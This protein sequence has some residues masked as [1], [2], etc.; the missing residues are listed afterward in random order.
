MK[1]KIYAVKRLVSALFLCFTLAVCGAAA[2]YAEE[3]GA[4]PPM[5]G[6]TA[7]SGQTAPKDEEKS[8]PENNAGEETKSSDMSVF[9]KAAT[10]DTNDEKAREIMAS[11]N[12][13]VSHIVNVLIWLIT[14]AL[15]V[16]T[17]FDII[18]LTCPFLQGILDG[19]QSQ[20][21]AQGGDM[22]AQG[23][24]GG[25]YGEL[26]RSRGLRRWVRQFAAFRANGW[27]KPPLGVRA[28]DKSCANSPTARPR[29]HEREPYPNLR[30]GYDPDVYH[31]AYSDSPLR[32][33]RPYRRGI[34][35]W[36]Y[37]KRLVKRHRQ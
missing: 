13:V 24:Y 20:G 29:R 33:R 32:Q 28:S 14:A 37:D 15:V 4:A 12:T 2:V 27:R 19:G 31:C 8:P 6:Q 16:C 36:G 10:I 17:L 30:Q 34:F 1:S 21:G 35:G 5:T 3:P 25:G 18:Y 9:I 11:G 23:G 7:Q 22:S 26:R